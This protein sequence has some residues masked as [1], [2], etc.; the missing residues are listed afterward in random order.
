VVRVHKSKRVTATKRNNKDGERSC[1][2]EKEEKEMI[3]VW[4]VDCMYD[5]NEA[6]Y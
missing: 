2:Q 1:E 4:L 5:C 6:K 3:V